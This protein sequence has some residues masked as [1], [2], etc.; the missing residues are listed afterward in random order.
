M[1]RVSTAASV[2][3][4]LHMSTAKA[5]QTAA[6]SGRLE[7]LGDAFLHPLRA[8]KLRASRFPSSFEKVGKKKK[9]LANRFSPFHARWPSEK[10]KFMNSVRSLSTSKAFTLLSADKPLQ[11][12]NSRTDVACN[13]RVLR[14]TDFV[15]SA[16][17]R[18][19]SSGML[20]AIFTSS[21]T[22]ARPRRCKTRARPAD[23]L[24]SSLLLTKLLA[25]FASRPPR[26]NASKALCGEA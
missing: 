10:S 22:R 9:T 3:R 24:S 23:F 12:Q 26:P 25:P 16:L 13:S 14:D 20:S 2:P 8:R 7:K 1:T 6:R 17:R 18:L 19:A 21:R 5:L 11:S 4:I 15:R